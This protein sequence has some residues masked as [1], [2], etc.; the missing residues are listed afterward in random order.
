MLLTKCSIAGISIISSV[1]IIGLYIF[2]MNSSLLTL[3]NPLVVY[4]MTNAA[5]HSEHMSEMN[6]DPS[7]TTTSEEDK[8]RFCGDDI[9]NSNLYVSEYTLPIQCSQ[10]VGIAVD[11]DNN[12][13]IASGKLGSL[14]VFNTKTLEFDK[15]IKIPN[16]PEQKRII[17][18]MI[19]EMKFDKNGNLWF[20]DELSNSI[21][22]Y[23]TKDG[24]FENYRLLEEGGYPQSISFDSDGNVWFTQFFGKRLGFIDPSKVITNTTEGISELDMSKQIDFQT[25][26]PI[27]NGFGF[28]NTNTN[29]TNTNETLWFSTAIFPMG[30]QIIK[31]DIPSESLTIHDVTYTHSVPFS[32]AE[33]E[34]GMLWANSHIA[35]LFFSLDPNT[36]A[37]KQ[38]ATSNPSASGNLTTLPYYNEYRDGKVWFNEHYGNAIASYDPENKTLVEYYVPSQN[39]LWVNSSNPL[40]FTFD[41][42]GSVWFTEWTENKLGVITKDR[43]DQIPITL[44]V[45]KN[46]L[47]LDSK[48][49][50]SD[51]IDIYIHENILN[52][53][54]IINSTTGNEAANS[55]NK[56]L[57]ITMDVT[58]SIAKNGKLTNLTSSF[59][60]DNITSGKKPADETGPSP[61]L[62][63]TLTIAPTKDVIPG[64]YTLTVSAKPN[65][66]ITVSKIV[67]IEIK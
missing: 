15:I 52:A 18:S 60:Q 62:N 54:K 40:R 27:S 21:W 17:G 67:D 35:N 6:H 16:W 1:I 50:K 36:G 55:I 13:W 23:F 20:T 42:N 56:S 51:S 64:N 38:Y 49:N 39:P 45:S 22:K 4:A 57:N 46:K 9:P 5:S 37:V 53:S 34:N 24:K 59:S 29:T 7:N 26:G 33:D 43:L 66:D 8:K 65:K 10:P 47:V 14:L 12:I 63:T 3:T 11:K 31:Y 48:N 41:N 25:M 28:T 61:Q 19:W 44:G 2:S 30:G 32:I 58:S